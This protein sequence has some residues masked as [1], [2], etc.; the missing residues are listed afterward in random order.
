MAKR[1][2]RR[3]QIGMRRRRG[4]SNF[5]DGEVSLSLLLLGGAIERPL[6]DMSSSRVPSS[7]RTPSSSTV[8]FT[9]RPRK[10]TS[11]TLT[12]SEKEINKVC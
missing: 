9:P 1:A 3:V 6:D 12:L 4:L 11:S 2:G 5:S 7:S 8:P 10:K